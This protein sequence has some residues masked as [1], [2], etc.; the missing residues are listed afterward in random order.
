MRA[1][2]H[3]VIN[4]G[5]P[6]LELFHN[7]SLIGTKRLHI[8]TCTTMTLTGPRY[9]A[10]GRIGTETMPRVLLVEDDE[11]LRLTQSLYLQREGF[12][13]IAAAGRRMARE[14]L[15]RGAFD[16]VVTDLR[17]GEE[18]G[19]DVLRDA[20]ELQP[21]AEVLVITGYG[22]VQSAV[23]AM[24]EGA[25]DYL[26]KPVDPEHLVR[27]LHK[28]IERQSLR[29]QVRRLRDDFA[30][31]AGLN[32]IVAESQPMK[33]IL[34][35]VEKIA[36]SDASVLIEG[37]SGTGKELLAR[38]IHER[39]SRCAGPFIG[40]NC[41]AMP[42]GLL[43]SELFGHVRGAF[44]GAIKDHKGLFE[45][46]GGGTLFLD[47]IAEI[48]QNSQVKLLR[49][50][51]EQTIRRVGDTRETRINVR[52]IAASNRDLTRLVRQGHF[53]QDLYFRIKVVPLLIP[54][55]RSR[56]DDLLP[57]AESFLARFSYRMGRRKPL[58]GEAA[59]KRLLRHDWPGNVR[60]MENTIER[61]LLFHKG[62]VLDACDL[63]LESNLSGH[64]PPQGQ[65]DETLGSPSSMLPLA[66]VERRHIL[67]V[68]ERCGNNKSRAAEVL[69]I[70]YNT[71]WRKLKKL[72]ALPDR[73]T[74]QD[75]EDSTS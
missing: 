56:P 44:T 46:A 25:Y 54:P 1:S 23:E 26:A 13:A 31:V 3:A 39:S 62:E 14:H 49:A 72:D 9:T 28:A 7:P 61:A 59:R 36:S 15:Q 42:E 20:K 63:L 5:Q 70:G 27:L 48:S 60:E 6:I 40:I 18:S 34:A 50:L 67:Q 21:G 32:S 19:I 58:L 69:G 10:T 4:R 45:A 64:C 37:E 24:R 74:L 71:L 8:P 41:G 57:L 35:A 2:P 22:S 51:Q 11:A 16:V 43:E 30:R 65:D 68:L 52:I 66:E 12:E 53:R 29:R 33:D 75:E 17:L 47:E 55:L 38:L 73:E